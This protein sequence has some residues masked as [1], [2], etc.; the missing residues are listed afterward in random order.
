MMPMVLPS[1]SL[2]RWQGSTACSCG[3]P[4]E[5]GTSPT[6]PPIFFYASPLVCCTLIL[7]LR[8]YG[9]RHAV[10]KVFSRL[11]ATHKCYGIPVS[12]QVEGWFCRHISTR[13]PPFIMRLLPMNDTTA[14]FLN[15]YHN[16]FLTVFPFTPPADTAKLGPSA[17]QAVPDVFLS[18]QS[19]LA[20]SASRVSKPSK[21]P[22]Y[23]Q[24]QV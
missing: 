12:P 7:R 11:F 20:I 14:N 17:S 4:H 23:I 13:T 1:L 18:Y 8:N 24:P 2:S 10:L 19:Y 15:K 9:R 6:R 21:C 16:I 22:K 5:S 3:L